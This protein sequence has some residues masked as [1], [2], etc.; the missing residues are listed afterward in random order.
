MFA[1]IDLTLLF[2]LLALVFYILAVTAILPAS[3]GGLAYIFL[4][5][6]IVMFIVWVL[7][8]LVGECSGR[9][10]RFRDRGSFV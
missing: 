5:V 7:F 6:A 4:V 10:Y 8:R 2:A 9:S 3:L 1:L